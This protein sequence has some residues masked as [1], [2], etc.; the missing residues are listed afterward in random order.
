MGVFVVF[1]LGLCYLCLL[2][3]MVVHVVYLRVAVLVR[4]VNLVVFILCV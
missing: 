4:G 3:C 2:L 1:M